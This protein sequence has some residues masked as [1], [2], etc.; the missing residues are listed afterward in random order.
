MDNL[1]AGNPRA[2]AVRVYY[3]DTSTIY[4]G[5]PVCYNYDT[6]VNWFGGSVADTG[7]VTATTA[8]AD[9]SQNERRYIEVEDPTDNNLNSFAGVVKKGGWCGKS[10]ARV[11]DIYVPNGAIVPVRCD[12]DTTEG[13]TI[14]AITVDSQELGQPIS[15]TSRPVAIAAETETEL[16]GGADITLATLDPNRFVYQNL[17]GTA[18]NVGVGTSALVVNEI[19]I[20]TAHTG[21][22]FNALDVKAICS[23]TITATAYN[24]AILANM[25][26]S[27]GSTGGVCNYRALEAQ[28]NLGSSTLT[29][30]GS[31]SAACKGVVYGVPTS[32]VVNIV[33]ALWGDY[34]VNK[35]VTGHCSV[36]WLSDNSTSQLDSMVSMWGQGTTDNIWRFAGFGGGNAILN[37]TTEPNWGGVN[38]KVLKIEIDGT[39]YYIHA[40]TDF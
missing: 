6:D 17:D 16:D 3:N 20:T 14:L 27:G 24:Y 29:G 35:T 2:H 30:G 15:G 39:S 37:E 34:A 4:E 21:G 31:I 33:C 11:L 36:L 22:D 12:V 19:N 28:L 18:L 32:A 25:A 40:S 23:G 5:M 38:N 1:T 13:V 8:T 26:V 10:G 7:E 9:G